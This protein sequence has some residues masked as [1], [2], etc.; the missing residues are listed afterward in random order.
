M[1][2]IHDIIKNKANCTF[3]CR[4]VDNED[5]RIWVLKTSG[6]ILSRR[7]TRMDFRQVWKCWVSPQLE[8]A[9]SFRYFAILP[10]ENYEDRSL[11]DEPVLTLFRDVRG[12]PLSHDKT[13]DIKTS[14]RFF[15]KIII[16]PVADFFERA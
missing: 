2:S 14:L 1:F 9:E 15:H 13:E 3:V 16:A 8:S 5:V 4:S 7:K 10:T 12:L 6:E 11:N